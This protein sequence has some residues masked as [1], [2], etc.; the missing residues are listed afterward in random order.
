M[1][2]SLMILLLQSHLQRNLPQFSFSTS[3]LPNEKIITIPPRSNNFL[4]TIRDV[5]VHTQP[6]LER[7]RTVLSSFGVK[8]IRTKALS[9]VTNKN[10]NLGVCCE[11]MMMN[12]K[13]ATCHLTCCYSKFG[14]NKEPIAP[15]PWIVIICVQRC[16]YAS[17]CV[18]HKTL[19]LRD[20]LSDTT[21][22]EC[23]NT[24]I[25]APHNSLALSCKKG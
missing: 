25:W 9:L 22:G 7:N 19:P 3:S 5:G 18:L 2:F 1:C 14:E 6:T 4:N 11:W 16:R 8:L 20:L 24:D 17:C 13:P 12:N 21:Y 23:A 15:S 10:L